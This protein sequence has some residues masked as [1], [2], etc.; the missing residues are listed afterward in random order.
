MEEDGLS[1]PSKDLPLQWPYDNLNNEDDLKNK[2]N[3]KMKTIMFF[4]ILGLLSQRSDYCHRVAIFCEDPIQFC[5]NKV[6]KSLDVPSEELQL[7]PR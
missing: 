2:D 7:S 6:S 3:L 5:Q 4:S 1:F